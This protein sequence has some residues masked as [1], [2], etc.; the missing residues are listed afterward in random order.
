MIPGLEKE[1]EG[2]K[3]GETKKVVVMPAEGYG[4][5]NSQLVREFDKSKMP[6]DMT[7]AKGMILEM[8]DEE[9]NSYPAMISEV[10]DKTVMLDFNHPLAGKELT[11]DVKIVS[12][13]TGTPPVAGDVEPA[14]E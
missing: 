8:Q 6:A 1:M 2:M 3:V 14:K 4:E 11:F 5:V 9:G 12:V 10:K 13:E 7:P